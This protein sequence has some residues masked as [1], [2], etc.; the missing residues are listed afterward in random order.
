M[1]S[2]FRSPRRPLL[3]LLHTVFRI[4]YVSL[5]CWDASIPLGGRRSCVEGIGSCLTS[6]SYAMSSGSSYAWHHTRR[7]CLCRSVRNGRL[8]GRRAFRPAVRSLLLLVLLDTRTPAT[9]CN[10]RN[11]AVIICVRLA[12]RSKALSSLGVVLRGLPC[13]G[14]SLTCPVSAC[15]LTSLLMTV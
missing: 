3:C 5:R 10:H 9:Q 13:L 6:G 2:G 15:F 7:T 8:I 4:I 1:C 14:R 11:R 12:R